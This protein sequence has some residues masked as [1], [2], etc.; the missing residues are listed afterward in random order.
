[1]ETLDVEEN[2]EASFDANLIEDFSP[3]IP[4]GFKPVLDTICE[5]E[6]L[7]LIRCGS[8]F[9]NLEPF[10]ICKEEFDIFMKCKRRRDIEIFSQIK[11]WDIDNFSKLT[12]NEREN[13]FT[14]MKMDEKTY[15]NELS[16]LPSSQMYQNKKWRFESDLDQIRWRMKYLENLRMK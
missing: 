8:V 12:S 13:I 9:G 6:F 7:K 11:K 5:M 10:S 1:M 4:K 3:T 14:E 16:N 15:K 2:L